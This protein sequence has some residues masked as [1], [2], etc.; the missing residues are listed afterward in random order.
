MADEVKGYEIHLSLNTTEVTQGLKSVQS[1]LS[2]DQKK[3]SDVNR[4]L[5][6]DPKNT[7][8]LAEK[9]RILGQVIQDTKNKLVLQNEQLKKASDDLSSGKISGAQFQAMKK[10]VDAT[11]QSL[12]ELNSQLKKTDDRKWEGISRLG[13]SLTSVTKVITATAAA[14]IALEVKGVESLADDTKFNANA[15]KEEIA[16]AKQLKAVFDD[17]KSSLVTIAGTVAKAVLP[18]AQKFSDW[19]KSEAVP[20]IKNLIEKISALPDST[21]KVIAV[22]AAVAVAAGPVISAIGKIGSAVNGV[23]TAF[24]AHPIV[25][26]IAAIVA[27]LVLCY[28]KSEAFRNS[29]N[30]LLDTLRTQLSGVFSRLKEMLSNLKPTIDKL[31]TSTGNLLSKIIPI[32]NG[33]VTAL[34]PIVDIVTNLFASLIEDSLP[35]VVDVLS[36]IFEVIGEILEILKPVLKI[37]ENVIS[38]VAQVLK[39]LFDPESSVYQ[40]IKAIS[41]FVSSVFEGVLGTVIKMIDDIITAIKNAVDWITSLGN[42]AIEVAD[43]VIESKAGKG[44]SNGGVLLPPTM[45][46][47]KQAYVP[48]LSAS[49]GSSSL[50]SSTTTNSNYNNYYVTINTTADHM[51]IDEIN[52]ALGKQI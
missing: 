19:V 5:K 13:S 30:D 12:R 16:A 10:N 44:A 21:K 15:T 7:T 27:V 17:L 28:Q 25:I 47:N 46:A 51:S 11:N 43:K 23:M 40:A 29:V 52:Y 9:Q 31:L 45:H 18:Y 6:F 3:L 26:I 49:V 37:I 2:A 24:S 42:K 32:I 48:E 14:L 4:Q 20:W 36:V 38:A 35:S 41:D 34:S 8:L 1:E 33:L 50:P 39:K 22:M